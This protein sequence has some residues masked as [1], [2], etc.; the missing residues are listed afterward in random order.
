MREEGLIETAHD[1][2][3]RPFDSLLVE[4]DP[5][6]D[7]AEERENRDRSKNGTTEAAD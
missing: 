1:K 3:S 4:N 5:A 2:G 6:V 7:D